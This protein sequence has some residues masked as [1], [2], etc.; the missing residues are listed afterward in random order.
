[1]TTPKR[2]TRTYLALTAGLLVLFGMNLL[3]GSV[4][5]T[6]QAVLAALLGKGQDALW[7]GRRMFPAGDSWWKGC[8]HCP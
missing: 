7:P 8:C 3:W 6:P 1:M 5:L 2:L 4:S